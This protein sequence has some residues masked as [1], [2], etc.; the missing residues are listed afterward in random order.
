MPLFP[1]VS[2]WNFWR[3]K[4]PSQILAIETSSSPPR[5]LLFSKAA[6]PR[7]RRTRWAVSHVPQNAVIH[8]TSAATGARSV[9]KGSVGKTSLTT[10]AARSCTRKNDF[11]SKLRPGSK[12][13]LA[14]ANAFC[15]SEKSN[16]SSRLQS[17]AQYP[18]HTHP[19]ARYTHHPI[20][21]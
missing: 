4:G 10:K 9:N 7:P 6:G 17:F 15:A 20:F 21:S 19:F 12:N 11:R 3:Q 1:V 5:N 18:S 2:G 13:A 14:K 8:V 16:R